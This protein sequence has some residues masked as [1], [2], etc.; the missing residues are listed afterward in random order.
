[1]LGK[2]TKLP[3]IQGTVCRYVFDRWLY[4][5]NQRDF[6]SN[7]N[8]L[9]DTLQYFLHQTHLKPAGLLMRIQCHVQVIV[10]GARPRTRQIP[11]RLALRFQV[12]TAVTN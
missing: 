1:M 10:V 2:R 4:Q 12:R 11:I 5:K 6:V 9:D 7:G 8:D 3:I